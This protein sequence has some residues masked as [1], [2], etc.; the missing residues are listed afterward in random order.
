MA[1]FFISLIQHGIRQS[2]ILGKLPE[3]STR[4][5]YFHA[6]G[7]KDGGRGRSVRRECLLDGG[8]GVVVEHEQGGGPYSCEG[9]ANKRG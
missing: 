3:I 4:S 7:R 1:C 2:E 9:D 5:I 6:R 8:L